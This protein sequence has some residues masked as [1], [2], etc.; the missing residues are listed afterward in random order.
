MKGL[1]WISRL[2][3][4]YPGTLIYETFD[5]QDYFRVK[6]LLDAAGIRSRTRFGGSSRA[7][8][9]RSSYGGKPLTHY[10]IYVLE[11]DQGIAMKAL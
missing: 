6:G 9:H 8:S 3:R 7:A 2:V 5:D 11:E 10:K 1:K 4:S